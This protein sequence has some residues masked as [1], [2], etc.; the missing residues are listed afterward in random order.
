M[1]P[2][3][4][5]FKHVRGAGR[6]SLKTVVRSLGLATSKFRALPDFLIIGA[7]RGGTTSF[8]FDLLEHPAI[9]KMFPPPI[10]GLKKV[11]TK[12]VHYFDSNYYRGDGWYRSY[13]PSDATRARVSRRHGVPALVGEAS[14]FYLF[15]PAAASRAFASVPDVRLIVLLRDPVM[16]TYSHWK[17]QRRS[18]MEPLE[19]TAAL[20]AEAS[21]LEGERDNLVDDARFASHAWEQQSYSAQ[22]EYASSLRPWLERFGRHRVFVAASED[23]YAHPNRVLGDVYEFLDLPRLSTATGAR[24]NAAAGAELD[25]AVVKRLRDRF[26]GPNHDLAAMLGQSF[27]WT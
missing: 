20:D 4:A 27:A 3:S 6:D 2:D 9:L 1:T 13:M 19:F 25:P 11:A 18:G 12:G 21:R 23:Y 26:A 16:R 17:Q 10:P 15:H 22:S 24:R 5:A 8:Y 7:K 14:P